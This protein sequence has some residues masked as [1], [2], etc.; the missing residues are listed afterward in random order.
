MSDDENDRKKGNNLGKAFLFFILFNYTL[1]MIHDAG[2]ITKSICE[3]EN[4]LPSRE[5]AR[6]RESERKKPCEDREWEN[7]AREGKRSGAPLRGSFE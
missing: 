1:L 6:V 2:S 4:K 3:K 7:V 5:D